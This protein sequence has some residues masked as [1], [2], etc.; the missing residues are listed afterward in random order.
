M[1][2]FKNLVALASI[3]I[4]A[5]ALFIALTVPAFL[6]TSY[7]MIAMFCSGITAFCTWSLSRTNQLWLCVFTA[8]WLM[9]LVVGN[10]AV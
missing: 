6:A 4:G 10:G 1:I 2:I 9:M 8:I 7:L 5:T 3:F